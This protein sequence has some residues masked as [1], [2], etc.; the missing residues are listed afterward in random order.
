MPNTLPLP[1]LA[2]V[3]ERLTGRDGT[4][5]TAIGAL[6]LYRSSVPLKS[7]HGVYKP[8]FCLIAQGRKQVMLG[9]D[10]YVYDPACFLLV[11]VDL[12]VISQVVDTS[13]EAP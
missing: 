11:A 10:V 6:N 9:E 4:F 1:E 3:L 5:P 12:P 2:A 13:P 8:S 7:I